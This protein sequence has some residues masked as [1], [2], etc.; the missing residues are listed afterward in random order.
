MAIAPNTP[1]SVLLSLAENASAP[2]ETRKEAVE[3]LTIRLHTLPADAIAAYAR[4][5]AVV[6]GEIG[7][8]D[9]N[10][11]VTQ[12]EKDVRELRAALAILLAPPSVSSQLDIPVAGTSAVGSVVPT[13]VPSS[14]IPSQV[15]SDDPPVAPA[16]TFRMENDVPAPPT[17]GALRASV[18]TKSLQG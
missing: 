16:P 5:I 4:R 1:M 3:D 2:I 13:P 14:P 12:L 10:I 7:V 9:E 18:T 15:R 8:A 17:S 11:R 6:K